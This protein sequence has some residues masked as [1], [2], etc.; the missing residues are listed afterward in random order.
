MIPYLVM[1]LLYIV[2][3]AAIAG[4]VKLMERRLARSERK[5]K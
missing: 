2:I 5:S 3:V 4:L 1:A